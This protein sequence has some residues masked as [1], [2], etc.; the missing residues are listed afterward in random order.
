MITSGVIPLLRSS[1]TECWVGLVFNSSDV[2]MYG[3]RVTWT[4]M[5]FSRPTSFPELADGL[6]ERKALD[7]TDG[8]PHLGDH[9]I[10]VLLAH[11]TYSILDLI[12]DVWDH[13]D[14]VP[15]V[16]PPAL[17]LDHGQI[18]RPG[19][20]VRSPLQVF[21]GEPLVV[22]EVEV[23]LTPVVGDEHLAV[24]EGVHRAGVDVDVGVELLVHDRE[25]LAT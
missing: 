23:G 11:P 18:D 14:R 5:T 7:V 3:T 15:Q 12:R 13:L 4:N 22:S 2:A 9:D 24:L 8:P 25:G 20:D 21:T 6:Q 10:D 1:A 16:V 19:G 17:L